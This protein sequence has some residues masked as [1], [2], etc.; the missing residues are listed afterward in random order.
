MCISWLSQLRS[1]LFGLFFHFSEFFSNFFLFFDWAS[2]DIF[3][4]VITYK[5]ITIQNQFTKTISVTI[6]IYTCH[7]LF[8][9]FFMKF[10]FNKICFFFTFS[11]VVVAFYA[12]YPVSLCH[13]NLFG[14]P[15][16]F[17]RGI[18]LNYRQ[19]VHCSDS[20]RLSFLPR[21]KAN[22]TSAGLD[23]P[24]TSRICN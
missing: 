22:H 20:I 3:L 5:F 7:I 23:V 6:G 17:L 18:Y 4:S 24:R 19:E 14:L 10:F 9:T 15:V 11:C 21:N 16:T 2:D 13:I 8:L 12:D 1:I